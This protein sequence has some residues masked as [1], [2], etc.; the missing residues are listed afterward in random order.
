[1]L[2]L[3][4][5]HYFQL[6]LLIRISTICVIGVLLLFVT[7]SANANYARNALVIGNSS[8][9][10]VSQLENPVNDASDMAASLKRLGFNVIHKKDA[11]LAEM[12]LAIN[13]Y[14]ARIKKEGGIGL[15]YYAGHGVQVDGA[16]YLIPVDANIASQS[17][18][19]FK[20]IDVGLVLAMVKEAKNSLNIVILDACR[21]NPYKSSFRSVRKGLAQIDAPSG[22]LIAYATAPGSVSADGTG[23]NGLYTKHLLAEIE[24]PGIPIERVFK[25]VRA[26]VMK[27]SRTF[28]IDYEQVPWESSSLVNDFYFSQPKLTDVDHISNKTNN[29]PQTGQ[30]SINSNPQEI[31]IFINGTASGHTPLTLPMPAGEVVIEGRKMG[32]TSASEKVN[33]RA[34]RHLKFSLNLVE[35]LLGSIKISSKPPGAQWYLDGT[36]MGITPDSHD[37]VTVG[38]RQIRISTVGFDDW[39]QKIEAIKGKRLDLLATLSRNKTALQEASR[40]MSKNPLPT[41]LQLPEM[42]LIPA[43]SFIMGDSNKSGNHHEQPTQKITIKRPFALSKYEVTFNEYKQFTKETGRRLPRDAGWGKENHPVINVSWID[44]NEYVK[45]LSKQT[46]ENYR[47]PTEAEWEYA[48]RAG[49]KTAFFYGDQITSEQANFN[50]IYSYNNGP[51]GEYRRHSLPVGS[52]SA[53]AFGL[54]DTHG[55]VWEWV[56]DCYQNNLKS[57]PKDGSALIKKGCRHH[58]LRG[59]SLNDEAKNIRSSYRIKHHKSYKFKNIG[60]RIARDEK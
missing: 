53:N 16:N 24:K 15:F 26:N 44:A 18:V 21:D 33:I 29:K 52:F 8:Y 14:A 10:H 46:G 27:E 37:A 35:N 47:L 31:E 30:L 34:N 23:R 3:K 43:G 2:Y 36:L 51:T 19:M 50:A 1:M 41:G 7:L 42:Q 25:G 17:E 49:S 32:Y 58:V 59:G 5:Y 20:S 40:K 11:S 28:G 55:N 12:G 22:T 60:F 9:Q 45:W 6:H 4:Q 57:T 48:H 13:T 54:Y 38:F 39:N 56:A